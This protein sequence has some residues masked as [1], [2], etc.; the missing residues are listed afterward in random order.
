MQVWVQ[1]QSH[2]VLKL[3]PEVTKTISYATT[4]LTET[5]NNQIYAS[6]IWQLV[7]YFSLTVKKE[8]F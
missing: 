8:C 3:L 5:D 1:R 4:A 2:V 6:L 7:Y